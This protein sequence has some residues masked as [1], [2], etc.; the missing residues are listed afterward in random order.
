MKCAQDF[1]QHQRAED[2]QITARGREVMM[3]RWRPSTLVPFSCWNITSQTN[4]GVLHEEWSAFFGLFLWGG[5]SH[6]SCNVS[7]FFHVPVV[8]SCWERL[9]SVSC[10]NPMTCFRR[11]KNSNKLFVLFHSTNKNQSIRTNFQTNTKPNFNI[12]QFHMHVSNFRSS[13]LI[14]FTFKKLAVHINILVICEV[15]GYTVC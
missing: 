7:I 11:N 1:H 12:C 4:I 8:V 13:S 15:L 9:K 5:Q 6:T 3:L 10:S 14:K 2:F